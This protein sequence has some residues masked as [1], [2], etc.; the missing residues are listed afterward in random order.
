MLAFGLPYSW[1][2]PCASHPCPAS[3]GGRGPS[4]TAG[5]VG[6]A[7]DTAHVVYHMSYYHEMSVCQNCFLLVACGKQQVRWCDTMQ[8]ITAELTATHDEGIYVMHV[9]QY[10]DQCVAFGRHHGNTP[11]IDVHGS[12]RL[13]RPGVFLVHFKCIEDLVN[14]GI[15]ADAKER[16]TYCRCGQD[17]CT[18]CAF[19]LH[20]CKFRMP[21]SVLDVG[22][23]I[24]R[25][26]TAQQ[27][28]DAV[29]E[30]YPL[31]PPKHVVTTVD[32]VDSLLVTLHVGAI[33][34]Y[35]VGIMNERNATAAQDA[36]RSEY[37]C[38][39]GR[40]LRVPGNGWYT[41]HCEQSTAHKAYVSTGHKWVD[42]RGR[43]KTT[44]PTKTGSSKATSIK[45]FCS[46]PK[47][48]TTNIE[49][50]LQAP[51]DILPE[52]SVK[53]TVAICCVHT[54]HVLLV[55]L[56]CPVHHVCLH[57]LL[58]PC[59]HAYAFMY[60][61]KHCPGLSLCVPFVGK[62]VIQG[63]NEALLVLWCRHCAQQHDGTCHQSF[64]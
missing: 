47:T 12:K 60:E 4:Q 34:S 43:K 41:A 48:A 35:W 15:K 59:F 64:T 16:A 31:R 58:G 61:V 32:D 5:L 21:V 53:N 10:G 52:S 1:Q 2:Q 30:M 44:T 45:V 37:N 57:M 26:V 38:V 36:N 20:T 7:P 54:V 23:T 40:P 25:E 62:S 8:T 19:M 39:R 3:T 13:P 28:W 24:L 22:R 46:P 29:K 63:E 27:I 9:L 11:Y 33:D 6:R 56:L 18:K 50:G 14:H 55:V 17:G 49:S 51:S 42:N